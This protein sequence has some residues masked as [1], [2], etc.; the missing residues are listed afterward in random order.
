MLNLIYSFNMFIVVEDT[1][2]PGCFGLT[3]L[4]II[5]RVMFSKMIFCEINYNSIS[6]E[7]DITTRTAKLVR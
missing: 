1:Q 6:K 2:S 7:W 3:G 5:V 4:D